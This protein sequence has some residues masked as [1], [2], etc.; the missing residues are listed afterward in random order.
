MHLARCPWSVSSVGLERCFDRAEV[1]GSSP[2]RSTVLEYF[3]AL[4]VSTWA[5]LGIAI[6]VY[7]K[8]IHLIIA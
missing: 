6:M 7:L 3:G 4:N 2:V 5:L 8:G 1:A